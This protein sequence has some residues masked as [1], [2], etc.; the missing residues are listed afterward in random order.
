M[1]ADSGQSVHDTQLAAPQQY[2]GEAGQELA[3]WNA[4][5]RMVGLAGSV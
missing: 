2:A 5:E 3:L 4:T 1:L